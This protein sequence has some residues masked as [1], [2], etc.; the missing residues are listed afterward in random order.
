MRTGPGPVYRQVSRHLC[1]QIDSG[2]WGP[3]DR[4][5]SENELAR[6]L[7]VNRLTVRQA[8]GELASSAVL[9]V[10]QGS[11]TYVTRPPDQISVPVTSADWGAERDRV[12]AAMRAHGYD[13]V[14]RLVDRGPARSVTAAEAL[15][16]TS[17]RLYR[18]RTRLIA[19]DEIWGWSAYWFGT[20]PAQLPGTGA[21]E[22]PVPAAVDSMRYRW[23][24]FSA[25]A[26]TIA[27]AEILEIPVGRP[28]LVREGVNADPDGAA[29]LYVCRRL[30]G[31]RMRFRVDYPNGAG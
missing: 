2:R 10:R 25:S 18:I 4:L 14:E 3:G 31:D 21:G 8:I 15:G 13:V 1:E 27:D 11:G 12:G 5:P 28:L 16:A 30:R 22:S 20:R 19:S 9:T 7:S 6:E 24:A 29:A 23:R 26:A 17:S